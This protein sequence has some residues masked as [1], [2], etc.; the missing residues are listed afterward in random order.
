MNKS[1]L[2][3]LLRWKLSYWSCLLLD[4]F[5]YLSGNLQATSLAFH[6]AFKTLWAELHIPFQYAICSASY[7]DAIWPPITYF[8]N[9]SLLWHIKLACAGACPLRCLTLLTASCFWRYTS[10]SSSSPAPTQVVIHHPFSLAK[11]DR[12]QITWWCRFLR[13]VRAFI[14]CPVGT[15]QSPSGST[16]TQWLHKD[17]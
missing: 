2:D 9:S 4:I 8:H 11:S 13:M 1:P 16:S 14:I 6:H 10:P 5:F 7:R 3:C 12:A 15:A 17:S